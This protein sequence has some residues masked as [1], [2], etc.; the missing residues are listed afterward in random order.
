MVMSVLDS[1]F[2]L[3]ESREHP[4]HVAL[5]QLFRPPPDA[6]PDFI[7]KFYRQLLEHTEID[8]MMRRRAVRG[9]STLGQWSW[10]EDTDIDLEYHVRHSALPGPGRVRELLALVSRLHGT[11]LDRHRPLWEMHVIEGLE[12]GRFAV[13]TKIHHAL[14]DGVTAVNRVTRGL[15]TDPDGEAIPPWISRPTDSRAKRSGSGGG[16]SDVVARIGD[17]AKFT[18]ELA[19]TPAALVKAVVSTLRDEAATLPFD[20]PETLFNVPIGGARRFA[21]QSWPLARVRA[22]GKAVDATV[23]DVA[24]AMVSGALRRFLLDMD[25]LPERSLTAALPVSLR[26]SDG[27]DD[28]GAGN[29]VGLILCNLA[30]DQENPA[31]R[32]ARIRAS[33]RHSKTILQS[34]SP[35][36]VGLLISLMAPGAAL[37]PIPGLTQLVPPPF[38][39]IISNVPGS[40]EKLYWNGAELV[41]SYPL[42]IPA[43]GQALNV[44]LTSYAGQLEFGITGCRTAVPHLQRLLGH[45]DDELSDLERA[46]AAG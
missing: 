46:V 8:A 19:S 3:A 29:A 30:T 26:G 33:T 15:T 10:S 5:L 14:M 40:R 11:L 2:L 1:A 31:T 20:A 38:N 34:L 22:V 32:L 35:T 25:Q 42:S 9:P 27:G 45:L 17:A 24:V 6:P 41:A 13:Y 36:Q 18:G 28:G 16:L 37:A 4:T 43:D 12:D 23:N 39:L 21:A 7:A 44:T